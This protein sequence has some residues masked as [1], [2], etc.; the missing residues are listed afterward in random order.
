MREKGVKSLSGKLCREK[1]KE[2]SEDSKNVKRMMKER[3]MEMVIN[4]TEWVFFPKKI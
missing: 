1:T 2:N 4:N 3:R